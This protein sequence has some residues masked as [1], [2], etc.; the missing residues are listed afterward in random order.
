MLGPPG[1]WDGWFGTIEIGL[2]DPHIDSHL[3]S[4]S[5]IKAPFLT[6]STPTAAVQASTPP[7]S[8]AN[9]IN[10]FGNTITLPQAPLDWT[11]SPRL[12]LG[13]R[14]AEGAGEV[15]LEYRLVAS[16]G[17]DTIPNFDAA[18]DGFLKSR[19]NA[20]KIN[21]TYGAS[22][23][24]TNSPQQNGTWAVRFGISAADVFFDSQARGR[25]ILLQSASSNFAGV[26]LPVVFQFHKPI[27]QSRISL[28]G[29]VDATGLVGYTRQHFSETISTS[30]M[31]PLSASVA[32]R[33]QSNGVGI[34]GV[35]GGASY[36]PW[37]AHL[38]RFTLGYTWQ[39][40][41]FVGATS[42]SNAALT[43]QGIFL[44]GEWRY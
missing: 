14:L 9:V 29:E 19:L 42:D 16:Q 40:W 8:A 6:P 28:Y 35:E 7:G 33:P 37:D 43:L 10:L 17:T 21:L 24:L 39:R 44:R 32:E 23:Y 4:G 1:Q 34:F 22:Q 11:A 26:G 38:W 15:Q 5:N 13:Y 25:Q 2:I 20:Q 41:Y 18:G 31:G 12:R 30:D 27:A 36:V 3:N